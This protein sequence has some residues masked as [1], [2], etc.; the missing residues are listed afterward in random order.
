[1]DKTDAADA[2]TL[3]PLL[4][5][6]VAVQG[7]MRQR[8][9]AWQ[10]RVYF[11]RDPLTGEK[12]WTSKT[13][14]GGK[15]EAQRALAALVAASDDGGVAPTSGTVSELLKRWFENSS[16]DFSPSTVLQT[17]SSIRLYIEPGL[18]PYPVARLRTEDIDR[19][20]RELRKRGG[21]NGKPL[22]PAT[23]KRAHV[24]LHRALE[25]AVRWGSIRTNPAH[26]AQVPRI[27][28]PDIHPPTPSEL[29]HLFALAEES[30]P[31]FA[32]FLLAAAA[33]GAETERVPGF[34]L[35]RHR[36][37]IASNDYLTGPGERPNGLVVKDTKT[38]GVR[39]VALDPKTAE[40]LAEHRRR[41]EKTAAACGA[42]MAPDAYVFSHEADSASPWRPDSTTRAFRLLVRRAG[43]PGVRLHDLRHYVATRL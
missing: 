14:K 28:A 38:H 22:A 27:P 15:R 2:S 18:G 43:T 42:V 16:A 8:G 21:Q 36:R 11:G 39:R 7:S 31:G 12:R 5:K 6:E 35:V 17:T 30:D 19:L 1:M 41:A 26:Q 3:P 29:V 10:L 13:V 4:A 33:T 23:V 20:Y 9:D 24:I 40:V 34:A 25:Q 32:T 37:S